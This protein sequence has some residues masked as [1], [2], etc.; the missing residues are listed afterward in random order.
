MFRIQVSRTG[1]AGLVALAAGMPVAV[2]YDV[3]R[4]LGANNRFPIFKVAIPA[5]MP[6]RQLS[7]RRGNQ[8]VALAGAIVIQSPQYGP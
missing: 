6:H 1:I 4:V 3:A 2:H 5:A 7:P 8:P